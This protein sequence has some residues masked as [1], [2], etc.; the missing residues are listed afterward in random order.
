MSLAPENNSENIVL[1]D[2]DG[3]LTCSRQKIEWS[4]VIMM[5][6]LI[7]YCLVGI[8]SGS[9]IEYIKKQIGMM[10][11]SAG[12]CSPY[13]I[14]LLPCNGTQLF[15][16]DPRDRCYQIRHEL[17]MK[18]HMHRKTN[19]NAYQE[20]VRHILELQV[21]FLVKNKFPALTGN[22]VSYRKSTVNWSP[23]GRDAKIPERD[24]FIK[25]DTKEKIRE[26]LREALRAR[27]GASGLDDLEFNLGGSTSIDIHPTGWDKTYALRHCANRT[28]WFVGDMCQPGGND[29][30]LWQALAPEGRAFATT[31]PIETVKIVKENILPHL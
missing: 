27:L 8:V 19:E 1:F 26:K 29:Y 10:W 21:E 5:R 24:A 25:L 12:S 20:L 30:S 28:V 6:E 22:F 13:D 17:N 18:E 4:T 16:F 3:T 31:G 2:M 11:T 23:V 15:V 7:K 14:I 9:P